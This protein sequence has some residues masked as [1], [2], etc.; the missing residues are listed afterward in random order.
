[1]REQHIEV[2]RTARYFLAGPEKPTEVWFCLHGYGQLASDFLAMCAPLER[3]DRKLVAPEGLSRFYGKGFHEQP[4]ASW[5]TRADREAEIR[6][7]VAY[8]D[9]VADREVPAGARVNVLGFSQGAA[10]ASRWAALGSVEPDRLV[11]WA[12]DVAHDIP[13]PAVALAHTRVLMVLGDRDA[14]ITPARRDAFLNRMDE[15]GMT[16][17]VRT[18]SGGHRLDD[19]L[20]AEL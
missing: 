13:D 6:D 12:G 3:P 2:T 10:T 17:E 8:L 20:L 14:L 1:M 15:A 5:M 11:C 4:G 18:F 16:Y 7:Y 19:T 9:R